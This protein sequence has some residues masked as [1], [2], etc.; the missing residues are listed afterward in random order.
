M[1]SSDGNSEKTNSGAAFLVIFAP[2][3]R[4]ME[5]QQIHNL[6]CCKI[7][8]LSSND[9]PQWTPTAKLAL[10]KFLIARTEFIA[11]DLEAFARHAKRMT[12]SPEDVK[13]LARRSPDIT[14]KLNELMQQG[15][16]S[17]P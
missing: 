1:D 2:L 6:V 8:K 16:S 11:N 17:E 12:I 14:A 10:T 5:Q 7:E 13:L 3:F 4:T 15:K 9:D